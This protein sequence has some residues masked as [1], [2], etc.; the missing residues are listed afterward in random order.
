[1]NIDK[2]RFEHL[3]NNSMFVTAYE[4]LLS[5]FEKTP[6]KTEIV[7]LSKVLSSKVRRECMDLAM[8]KATECAPKT[9][10]LEALLKLVIRLNGETM[11]G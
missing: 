8:S 4:F 9:Y 11:Y 1:M 6:E 3:I 10:E 5:E 2:E 7:A